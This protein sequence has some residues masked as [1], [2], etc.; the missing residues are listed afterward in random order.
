MW[1]EQFMKGIAHGFTTQEWALVTQVAVKAA[2]TIASLDLEKV[3]GIN[4]AHQK[5]YELVQI[6][7]REIYKFPFGIAGPGDK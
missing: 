1:Q 5:G 2:K 4:E 3:E 7:R 6:I